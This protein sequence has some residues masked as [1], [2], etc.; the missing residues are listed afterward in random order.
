MNFKPAVGWVANGGNWL[1]K[2]ERPSATGPLA[3][4]LQDE[5]MELRADE[6]GKAQHFTRAQTEAHTLEFSW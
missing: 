2:W 4:H 3:A 5:A 6:P 1:L